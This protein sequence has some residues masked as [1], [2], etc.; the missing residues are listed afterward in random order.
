MEKRRE[1]T[2]MLNDYKHEILT[3]VQSE[4]LPNVLKVV[5]KF[6]EIIENSFGNSKCPL[7]IPNEID[8]I[9]FFRQLL[10][11]EYSQI[12]NNLPI[13][14]QKLQILDAAFYQKILIVKG[15]T[16]CGKSTQ[17]PQYFFTDPRFCQFSVFVAQPRRIAAL[18]LAKRIEEKSPWFPVISCTCKNDLKNIRKGSLVYFNERTLLNVVLE[19]SQKNEPFKD[20]KVV[21]LDEIHEFSVDMELILAL[22]LLFV[23]PKRP[24][25]AIILASATLQR[26]ELTTYLNYCPVIECIGKTHEV[27]INYLAQYENYYYETL[28]TI[29]RLVSTPEPKT[30]L[31]FLTALHQLQAAQKYIY[32][33][34]SEVNVLLLYGKQT[35][36]EQEKV[37]KV[38]NGIL[39]I[40]ATNFAES[41]LTIPN[42][43]HVVDCGREKVTANEGLSQFVN[44]TVF[45]SKASAI[46]RKGRTGREM[47]GH[48][49]RMYTCEEFEEMA[50][51]K[52][53]AILTTNLESILVKFLKFKL[54]IYK[55]PLLHPPSLEN[56]KKSY[57]LLQ[58]SN[59][60]TSEN[61]SY[62]LTKL[63]FFMA[64]MDI[65]PALSKLIWVSQGSVEIVALACVLKSCEFLFITE[66]WA[67]K[68]F[69]F[70]DQEFLQKG[71]FLLAMLLVRQYL[72]VK[73]SKCLQ[74]YEANYFTNECFS[75]GKLR[76]TW[77]RRYKVQIKSMQIA[78]DL[79]TRVLESLR[80]QQ[81]PIRNLF[82]SE[83]RS[84]EK[85]LANCSLDFNLKAEAA[86]C[87][88][89]VLAIYIEKSKYIEELVIKCF[90]MNLVEFV[91]SQGANSG[92]LRV[93][94]KDI[95]T[96]DASS[97]LA[98]ILEPH[99]FL[100]CYS[101]SKL[102]KLVMKYSTPVS[103]SALKQLKN[104][105]L[106]VINWTENS[107]LYETISFPNKGKL[108]IN[109][110]L[111][112]NFTNLYKFE[113]E[114][115]KAHIKALVYVDP[116]E[117]CVNLTVAKK[118]SV[119]AREI[120]EKE[121][122]NIRQGII[123]KN[124]AHVTIS[125]F[126]C[127]ILS[128]G[129]KVEEIMTLHKELKFLITGLDGKKSNSGIRKD[130]K[131]TFEFDFASIEHRG[132]SQCNAIVY[133][134]STLQAEMA[135]EKLRIQPL[136]GLSR[137]IFEMKTIMH[138]P[139]KGTKVQ[140]VAPLAMTDEEI[141][142]TF[143]HY[144]H[145]SIKKGKTTA[146]STE[147]FIKFNSY[148][149]TDFF[150]NN[151]R[152]M[153]RN[154]FNITSLAV[155]V[156]SDISIPKN[157]LKFQRQ[158][159]VYIRGICKKHKCTIT[160]N[161]K[162]TRIF[163]VF[164]KLPDGAKDAIII[165]LKNA[166]LKMPQALWKIIKKVPHFFMG[167]ELNWNSWMA[168]S[169]VSCCFYS[170]R[171]I[172]VIYGKP[173]DRNKALT[174]LRDLISSLSS[175]IKTVTYPLNRKNV[176]ISRMKQL[177]MSFDVD[178]MIDK[179]RENAVAKG[180]ASDISKLPQN[181]PV[182]GPDQ[183]FSTGQC[184]ICLDSDFDPFELSLCGH[185]IHKS[186]FTKSINYGL[187]GIASL[188]PITCMY[189][190][191]LVLYDDLVKIFTNA[192]LKNIEMGAISH[193]IH[194]TGKDQYSWCENSDCSHIYD[195]N[196][197]QISGRTIRFCPQCQN[198]YC[199][200]CKM[201]A[202]DNHE[203]LCSQQVLKETSEENFA[204]ILKNTTSC[205]N[206]L[207]AFEKSGGCNHLECVFCKKHF[208]F[209]CQEDITG[210]K[211]IEHYSHKDS[212]C[213]QR[214]NK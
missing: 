147:I 212:I 198:K 173:S 177:A 115:E 29:E 18:N 13:Y 102:H 205:P 66:D 87:A 167:Q 128:P 155:E 112:Q 154:N 46:Q 133:F 186:C 59:A 95:A 57:M 7:A 140:L 161:R 45:I 159:R 170:N 36:K 164:D 169:Q 196:L 100:I 81:M 89:R 106:N 127:V 85:E 199:S 141:G 157:L 139:E 48:C 35:S 56:I 165:L 4:Y 31:V 175:Q 191:E 47:K 134:K 203:V 149:D 70:T 194:T 6:E 91:G 73:C 10:Q 152:T 185:S 193:Y 3:F 135:I 209:I 98:N 201:Q 151:C 117:K 93:E 144:P 86:L 32:N 82:T 33:F 68:N 80:I 25:L 195:K 60:I 12:R 126:C 20:T 42:V 37:L 97:A 171:E 130:L 138:S 105:Y 101:F 27:E 94:N 153:M 79:F 62:Q 28:N 108:Y 121:L 61:N 120:L 41:S 168:E 17:I 76:K 49:F 11:L 38:N 181:F 202:F 116:K 65:D 58:V 187:N 132:E 156:L 77:A 190:S 107:D 109:E 83:E 166:S 158:I 111:W 44:K 160:V 182:S 145:K 211:P 34:N 24:D 129:C 197:L 43:T 114:L 104:D 136:K 52:N 200:Y 5:G 192:M 207:V 142:N 143:R 172:F 54:D 214:Y 208:C 1:M 88:Q 150:A 176:N 51:F 99:Q 71:D 180:L 30:I 204:W 110:I 148:E 50:S 123:A 84:L 183:E 8:A 162:F 210:I 72:F 206:C 163:C 53:P 184:E 119:R 39:V 96:P 22:M 189:C 19:E 14:K 131:N 124:F 74:V 122:E 90:A 113:K 178:I 67:K 125:D 55:L 213:F 188:I 40:L 78:A 146:S 103:L 21:I 69:Y 92:Y 75:C 63:G 2:Q 174:Y 137:S 9:S 118:D 15:D 23:K 16:G 179:N 26:K 64:S